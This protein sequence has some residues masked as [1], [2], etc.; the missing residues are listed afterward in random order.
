[1]DGYKNPRVSY[2]M[3]IDLCIKLY[4]LALE[5]LQPHGEMAPFYAQTYLNLGN[6]YR[7][8][9][10]VRRCCRS[11]HLHHPIIDV[12]NGNHMSYGI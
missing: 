5:L 3:R 12:I 1:M 7:L 2:H 8:R 4:V 9:V 11:Y 10:K 6:A